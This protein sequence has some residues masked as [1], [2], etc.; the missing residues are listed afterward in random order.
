[1]IIQIICEIIKKII[2]KIILPNFLKKY[3]SF[4]PVKKTNNI[5]V[6]KTY[7]KIYV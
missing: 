7:I 6:N 1:M 2:L 3:F 5:V 4:Y